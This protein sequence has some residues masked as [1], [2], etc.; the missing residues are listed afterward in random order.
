MLCLVWWSVSRVLQLGQ[1]K[2][3]RTMLTVEV[4]VTIRTVTSAF[5]IVTQLDRRIASSQYSHFSIDCCFAPR[6]AFRWCVSRTTSCSA[7]GMGCCCSTRAMSRFTGFGRLFLG[8]VQILC[9]DTQTYVFDDRWHIRINRR[10]S[11]R[12]EG[13]GNQ[14][15]KE[16]KYV[17]TGQGETTRLRE[18]ARVRETRG[19]GQNQGGE[20]EMKQVGKTQLLFPRPGILQSSRSP[21]L[22]FSVLMFPLH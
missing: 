9:F 10:Q 5:C 13:E 16:R 4:C 18:K 22:S 15:A 20:R 11:G 6:V 3:R 2:F 1:R 12:V 7:E 19:K 17:R 14:R 8:R 21:L